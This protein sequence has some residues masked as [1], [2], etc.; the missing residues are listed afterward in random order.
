MRGVLP[1]PRPLLWYARGRIALLP[2]LRWANPPVGDKTCAS[3]G[4]CG[5]ASGQGFPDARSSPIRQTHLS[6]T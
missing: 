5:G 6:V 4:G 1:L 2:R 3:S